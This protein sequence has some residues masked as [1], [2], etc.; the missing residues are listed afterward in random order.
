MMVGQASP[1][2][3]RSIH[4]STGILGYLGTG[5]D[6]GRSCAFPTLARKRCETRF[7]NHYFSSTLNSGS[8]SGGSL[9]AG[10]MEDLGLAYEHQNLSIQNKQI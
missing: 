4:T 1:Y 6:T 2:P 5:K 7:F 10:A 9:F 3:R 8:R